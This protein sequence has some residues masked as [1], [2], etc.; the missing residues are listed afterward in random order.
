MQ[1]LRELI[2]GYRFIRPL[3]GGNNQLRSGLRI[4]LEVCTDQLQDA[5][6]LA[7]VELVVSTS[8]INHQNGGGQPQ[9]VLAFLLANIAPLRRC[10]DVDDLVD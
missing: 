4:Q 6:E 7:F 2:R 9:S 3:I 8:D 5:V 10:N 1:E